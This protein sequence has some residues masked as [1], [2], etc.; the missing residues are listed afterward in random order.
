LLLISRGIV[1][2]RWSSIANPFSWVPFS[3]FLATDQD[4]GLL[5]FFRKSFWYGSAVWLLRAGGWRLARA[6]VVVAMLLAAIEAIQIHLPG[7][8]AETTDPLLSLI[9][10]WTF[11]LLDPS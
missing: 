1:P 10:G 2:Y 4:F 8:V 5:V 7:R 11:G 6:A 3:G 9:L